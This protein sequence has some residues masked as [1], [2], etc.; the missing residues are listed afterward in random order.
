MHNNDRV[1]ALVQGVIDANLRSVPRQHPQRTDSCLT[2]S[3]LVDTAEQREIDGA[4]AV[5]AAGCAYCRTT[6]RTARA[7]HWDAHNGW[8]C[9]EMAVHAARTN[10]VLSRSDQMY[11]FRGANAFLAA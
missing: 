11:G 6:L 2:L 5:H 1:G 4:L 3:L 10:R 8:A 9:V 7:Y